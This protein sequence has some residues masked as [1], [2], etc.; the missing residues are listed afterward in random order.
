MSEPRLISPLLDGLLMGEPISDHHGVR[1]CPAMQTD[2]DNKYI[3]KIISIPA[4]SVQ[5]DALLLTGAYADRE[6]ALVYFKELADSTTEEAE[7]LQRLSRLEGFAGF[8]GW[9]IEPMEDGTGYDVYLMGTYRPTL[10]RHLARNPMTHLGA[11]NLGLDLC[12]ALSVCR[13][14]GYLYVDLKPGNVF[15]TDQGEYRIGDLGFIPID[16]LKFASLPDKY[17]SA[18]T[19]PEITDAFSALNA[20]LDIYAA[21]LILYQAYNNGELPAKNAD[22]PLAPPAYADYEMAE[23]IL[24]ACAA[25][26]E[27]R[28]Q[29]PVE[30]GQAL[31][32][33]MQRNSVNDNPI[34][35]PPVTEE[36]EIS[37]DEMQAESAQET[38]ET[39]TVEAE[40]IE[41]SST[42]VLEED[43]EPAET[44]SDD[45]PADDELEQLT[46][47][48][49]DE[50][51]PDEEIAGELE[52]APVSE[53][54]SQMLAQAD[55]LIA[56]ETPDPVIPPDPI[57]VPMPPPIVPEPEVSE[58]STQEAEE[59][60]AEE[61]EPAAEEAAQEPVAVVI[62]DDEEDYEE[63]VRPK[64]SLK[65]RGLIAVLT[66]VLILLVLAVGGL[67]FYE[68]YYIQS[69]EDISLDGAEDHLTVMLDTD[70]DNDLLTVICTDTY[71]NTKKAAVEN[72]IARF[73]GLNPDTQY[74]VSV[75]ISGFH[76]LI[77]TTTDSY[78]TTSR[79]DIVSFTAITGAE[80]GSVIL[81]FSVQGED[82]NAWRVTYQ[83]EG[84]AEKTIEF[85][86]RMVTITGLTVGS[87]YTFHLEPVST[88]YV[89][90]TDTIEYT[91][92]S[93]I[94]AEN[95]TVLG[96]DSGALK[97]S[98]NAPEGVSVESWTVRCYNDTG[99][100]STFTVTDAAISIPELDPA[101]AYTLDINAAGMSLG[102]KAYVSANSVTVKDLTL[103]DS[104]PDQLAISWQFEGTAPEGGWLVL[105]T[106]NGGE[107][108]VIRTE[109]T[110]AAITPLIPGA[111]YAIT[112]QP[113]SGATVFG[114]T[115]EY[116]AAGGEAFSSYGVTAADITF[117]MCWT[118]ANAN[119]NW[120]DLWERDFTTVF[121]NGE[122]AS[123][124]VHLTKGAETSNDAVTVLFVIR[125]SAGNPIG[126]GTNEKVWS[127]MWRDGYA[128]L[129]MPT[130]PATPGSYTVDIYFN[131]AFVTTQSF[132]IR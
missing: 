33:Y 86:G 91:A 120:Y 16:S 117:R 81:N 80:D 126:F 39:E 17:R 87:K 48:L 97:V 53:E 78:T 56:H 101:S 59:P 113:A 121:T 35:P 25:D 60:E 14:S 132:T 24:K 99:Y 36:P 20:T 115:G 107:A 62:L 22:E 125:D 10:E 51:A 100:D 84:E 92:S 123:F 76:Q 128:E 8:E 41:V 127:S 47:A 77:G 30:M 68:H 70:V 122:R 129:N 50:T 4:S 118:P 130:L 109:N 28:W 124:V 108:Q 103:D 74:K 58:E 19:A 83:A 105:Y 69:I 95:I 66:T 52:D 49:S 71:G 72:N 45:E 40:Q 131:G 54:V 89:I 46:F 21:G 98:W 32:S 2:S 13:Q 3:I 73:E 104:T 42:D 7:L 12:A 96:F 102:T 111:K 26:P 15:I 1:C 114:G 34:V 93:I 110:A 5:L 11:V 6:S 90:G 9:Q 65:Y 75:E 37:E 31:V 61:T 67:L 94:Y 44:L 79:T 27:D 85:T 88:Q 64:A 38:T 63:D 23:I 119:W 106:V 55:D 116:T 57:D 43:D 82:N 29:T 112:V 18:Y